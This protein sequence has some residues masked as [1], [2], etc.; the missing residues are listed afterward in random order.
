MNGNL[1]KLQ[2]LIRNL[3]SKGTQNILAKDNT[4]RGGSLCFCNTF[5]ESK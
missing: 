1:L 2:E 3:W 4:A 5:Y